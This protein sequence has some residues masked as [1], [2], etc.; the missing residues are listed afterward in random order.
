MNY[1]GTGTICAETIRP[2]SNRAVDKV[3]TGVSSM[4]RIS[5][6]VPKAIAFLEDPNGFAWWKDVHVRR[7]ILRETGWE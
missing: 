5:H 1:I 7:Q 2:T 6:T 3:C 4:F